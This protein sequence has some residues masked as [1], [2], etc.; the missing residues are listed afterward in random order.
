M[1]AQIPAQIR[2]KLMFLANVKDKYPQLYRAALGNPGG[3]GLSGLGLTVDEMIAA[4]NA[5]TD[6]PNPLGTSTPVS[7]GSASTDTAVPWYTNILNSAIDTIKQLTP[8]YVGT[9]Q[10]KTCIQVNAERAKSGL[11]PI[12]C[13]SGGLAPQVSVGISPDVKLIMY[14]GLGIG[15]VYL[16]MRAMR[17][18]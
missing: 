12:D 13:A 9:Q 1:A 7:S 3:V 5:G 8:V 15:A 10:A 2:A 16:L 11:S 4:Q 6:F 18:R 17:K 14:V